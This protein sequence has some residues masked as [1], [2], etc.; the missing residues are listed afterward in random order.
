MQYSNCMY[1]YNYNATLYL[2]KYTKKKE[3]IT[4][5]AQEMERHLSY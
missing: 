5:C 1:N 3:I 4:V 2:Q